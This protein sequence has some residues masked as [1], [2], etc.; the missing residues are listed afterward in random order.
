MRVLY[1]YVKS[2]LDIFFSLALI[3]LFSPI[4][5]LLSL[6]V[7]LS[8]SGPIFFKQ[9]R[10]GKSGE[11]FIIYKFRTMLVNAENM[12]SGIFTYKNDPRIT[13]VGGFLR[14]TSLDE[15]PQLFN[16]LKGEMSFIGPRPPVTY[17]PYKYEDYSEMQKKRF[18]VLPGITGLAQVNGR[19]EL[20]WE[21]RIKFDIRYV[22]KMSFFLDLKIL[23][24]TV[25]KLFNVND[26]YNKK[27]ADQ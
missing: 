2:L 23:L 25:Y 20:P 17:Y 24:L 13:K 4:F 12:G 21:E 27:N 22:E 7:K 26:N 5:F 8:S 18:N 14:K 3:I 6:L 16:I 1:V 9:E 10:L 11:V 15:L 19:K